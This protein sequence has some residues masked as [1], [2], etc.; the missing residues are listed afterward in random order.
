MNFQI[1]TGTNENFGV[2]KYRDIISFSCQAEPDSNCQL[3]LYA[4]D[5]SGVEKIPMTAQEQD[6]I[7]TV[8]IRGFDWNAYDYNFYINGVE[9]T[10]PY[11][12]SITGRELWADEERRP[13]EQ[14]AEE[15]I[16]KKERQKFE[17]RM[18]LSRKKIKSRFYFSDFDWKNDKLPR[19]K[20][21]DMV[22]YKL[23]PRGFSM[24]MNIEEN[25]KGTVEAIEKKLSYFEQLGVTTLM[26]LPFYE[27]EEFLLLDDYNKEHQRGNLVNYWG[28]T[29]G[30]YFA[31]K[32]SYLGK[33]GNPDIL[34]RLI[35]KLHGKNMECVLE[36][37]F[38]EK[39]NP[40][41]IID[42]LHYWYQE[43]H[44]DGFKLICS[45]SMASLIAQDGRLSSCKLFFEGFEERLASSRERFGPQLFSYNDG[46]LY[47]TRRILNHQG[48]SIYE[49]ACQ[50]RRQQ[51]YQGFVNYVAEN[52]GFTLLDLF[53]YN[54]KHNEENGEENQ[55]GR[56]WNYSNNCGQEGS[57][58]KKP[59]IEQRK[60]QMKNALAVTFLAQ[61]VPMLWMGDECA[62][63]QNGNNNAYCQDSPI[64]WK[65]WKNQA[66]NRQML[67]YTRQL[68]RIRR[69]HPI[70]RN[71]SPFQM[72]DYE[73]KGCPDLSYHSEGGWRMDFERNR[74]FIGMFYFNAYAKTKDDCLY[75]AYNFQNMPQKFALPKGMEWELVLDTAREQSILEQP[76][77]LLEAR[78]F[79]AE[80]QSVCL[81]VG[82]PLPEK[83]RKKR[84]TV[85]EEA[86]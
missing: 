69:E 76:Q 44:V 43:Y 82:K 53:S 24:G 33:D 18:E 19:I 50:M 14:R 46:F 11:A 83:K 5:G 55:D 68:S 60:R 42:V 54:G 15:F 27:F 71:P 72:M 32:A 40:H 77:R 66:L 84:K 8:G 39:I 25:K 51:E 20:K 79:Q 9:V 2:T 21:E 57:S 63:T 12:K 49:F 61:G 52:N 45:G 74:S 30:S 37:Y 10:D 23:H 62:N 85:K 86:E 65:D 3:L 58:R 78:E 80:E 70:L 4:R 75:A 34:K 1:C 38:P 35:K 29:T 36:F 41:L 67:Q 16:P 7:Y 64:G 22:I 73:N 26:F 6:K 81:L 13:I 17:L 47:G 31:P 56:D 48:G 28:Y 59:I